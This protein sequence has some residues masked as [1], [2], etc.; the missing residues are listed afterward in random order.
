MVVLDVPSCLAGNPRSGGAQ[1]WTFLTCRSSKRVV[2]VF[3]RIFREGLRPGGGGDRINTFFV[4]FVPFAPWDRRCRT[5][6]KYKWIEGSDLVYIYLTYESLAKYSP[7]L[8]ADGHIMGYKKLFHLTHLMQLGSTTR[9]IRNIIVWWQPREMSRW[10]YQWR[11]QRKLRPSTDLTISSTASLWMT[12][13]LIGKRFANSSASRTN[14]EITCLV[15]TQ[16]LMHGMTQF[17]F[18]HWFIVPTKKVTDFA[19][20]ACSRLLQYYQ[21]AQY[22][23]DDWSAMEWKEEQE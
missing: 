4:H 3:A 20:H 19:Q 13:R 10:S 17:R 5:I 11:M 22:A 7:R 18:L 23:K 6:L 1:H 2:R 21:F 16:V 12:H 8:S 9:M 15:C 14:I